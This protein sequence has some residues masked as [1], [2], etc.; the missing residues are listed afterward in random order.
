V[1]EDD[2]VEI[3]RTYIEGLFPRDCPQCGLRFGS[4]REYLQLTRHVGSPISYDATLEEIPSELLGTVSLANCA[5]GTT[6]T[7]SSK[8]M[9]A[10][11]MIE[12]L[13]WAKQETTRRSIGFRELL[14]DVRERIDQKVLA[15]SEANNDA[16]PNEPKQELI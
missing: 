16:D 7:I 13:K 11:Q 14:L 9:P 8:N 10:A 12:L 3:V 1:N 4:L 6:L 5:C 15:E 2:V